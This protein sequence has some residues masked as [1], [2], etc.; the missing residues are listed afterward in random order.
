VLDD[1]GHDD[2][3]GQGGRWRSNFPASGGRAVPIRN[4]KRAA[5]TQAEGSASQKE[6]PSLIIRKGRGIR[7]DSEEGRMPEGT[8][9]V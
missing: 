7:P 4:P 6:K 9:P 8:C 2:V 3:K 5:T 1:D